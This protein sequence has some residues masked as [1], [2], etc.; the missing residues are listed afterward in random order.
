MINADLSNFKLSFIIYDPVKY[1]KSLKIIF[2]FL[3]FVTQQR[4]KEIAEKQAQLNT[5]T[6]ELSEFDKQLAQI[7]KQLASI[8]ILPTE[9]QS[10]LNQVQEQINKLLE[11]KNKTAE[12]NVVSQN[13]EILLISTTVYH[14]KCL[15]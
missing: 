8:S 15:K 6:S 7:Q 13:A 3:L 12:Q 4:E 11:L 10:H 1:V 5:A 14:Q 9:I 2:L